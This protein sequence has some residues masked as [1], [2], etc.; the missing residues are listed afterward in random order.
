MLDLDTLNP[1]QREA[2]ECIDG[3]LLVL[4]GAGSGKTRVLTY[5]IAHMIE[6][7]GVSPWEVLAITFTNKAAAE[8][9][10]RLSQLVGPAARG[11]W[12]S[13]F[14]SMCVRILRADAERLGFTKNFT[15]YDDSDSKSLIKAIMYDLDIDPK[16]IPLNA[17]RSRIST[18]KNEL[19]MPGDFA[20]QARDP[21]AKQ[22]ARVYEQYQERL[23]AAN[24]FD[25]DDLLVYAWLLL[26]QNKDVL[27]AYQK[28]FR[29]ILVDEYQDTNHAQ[30]A[31][32]QL[33]AAGHKN[34]MV[35]GDDD[36]SIYSWRGA[37][38]RNILEFEHD[39]PQAHVV[40][41]EKN[42]RSTAT[43]LDAANAVI[44]NN[45]KRKPKRL[46]AT[47][48]S[49]SKIQVYMASDERDEG[50][51]IAGEIEHQKGNGFGYDQ[52]AVFYR[53]NA[54]SRML[55]D[56]LLRAGIP[57][58][59][60]GGTRFFDRAEIRDVMA[61]LNLVVNPADDIAAQRVVNVPRR[62]IGKT[63]VEHINQLARNNGSSFMDAAQLAVADEGIRLATRTA[64]GEFTS[65]IAE[66]ATWEGDLR[67]VVE[68]IIDRSGLVRA[69][70]D[71]GTDE[72]RSRVENVKEFLGV[73]DEFAET[74]DIEEAFSSAVLTNSGN[75]DAAASAGAQSAAPAIGSPTEVGF[76]SAEGDISGTS[77]TLAD[78]SQAEVF[79]SAPTISNEPI[80]I[81]RGDSLADFIEWVALRTDL[82]T[83]TDEGQAVT[84]MTIHSAKGLEFDVVFVA[85]MEE[86]IF[87]HMMSMLDGEGVEEER[88]LAYVAITR[89]RQRLY[90]TCAAA[91]SLFGQTNANP[92]SRFLQE[93]PQELR[94]TS[95]LGSSG[96]SGTGWEKRGSRRG[97]SGSGT[98]A[99]EGRVFGTSSAS[100]SGNRTRTFSA[101]DHKKA[102]AGVSFAV[103]DAVDHKV[104]GRGTVTAV[105]GDTLLIKFAKTG[106]EKKLLKDYAPIV[107]I[108]S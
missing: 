58:R 47:G 18:A 94:K 87:P 85:G 27:D 80:R 5:R 70:E 46:V 30:Y 8:M 105:D 95:G 91:R 42:Y 11:M 26:K 4:A 14:H 56:M 10:E 86:G 71:E 32:T 68:M 17:V 59:I 74:H 54:Q 57:Y 93:I 34:I 12:V 81:L 38:I 88:R 44:A 22:A 73:V 101:E 39:Y 48:D 96:F 100:G 13:T 99:G 76:A 66:A 64:L 108:S 60:V 35:V 23:R 61:Y 25:F 90:L 43:I 78:F 1:E 82:D 7:C 102:A 16:R 37:D 53:T 77:E 89:A 67:K 63:T 83:M 33:L 65:L 19:V 36:Q 104:F 106:S 103:G 15:I 75:V 9:R 28:R 41:L 62:G 49:G 2:V 92:T 3:P 51:W 97:I 31:I 45:A 21:I 20:D 52:M 24:A 107:K 79:Y 29:Y 72:A 55:E 98:E 50:R 69:L 40:K 84:L 6:S